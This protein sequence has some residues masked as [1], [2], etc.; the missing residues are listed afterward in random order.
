MFAT[1]AISAAG[2]A[3]MAFF[4]LGRWKSAVIFGSFFLA[5]PLLIAA[6]R[7]LAVRRWRPEAGRAWTLAV[8]AITS[9]MV[10]EPTLQSSEKFWGAEDN[11][12]IATPAVLGIIIVLSGIVSLVSLASTRVY[13]AG[14]GQAAN[15][16]PQTGKD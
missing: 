2:H 12:L 3:L 5:Q 1:F 6:E 4:V 7:R 10:I 16:S 15:G 8:L 11:V 14:Q 9:P 13:A